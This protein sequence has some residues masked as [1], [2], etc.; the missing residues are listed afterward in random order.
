MKKNQ[1]KHF[2][3][4]HGVPNSENEPYVI[5]HRETEREARALAIEFSQDGYSTDLHLN[6]SI[7][8]T[9][10]YAAQTRS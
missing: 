4:I 2:V 10:R 1:G 9:E 5:Q 3:V 7:R 8:P 6:D